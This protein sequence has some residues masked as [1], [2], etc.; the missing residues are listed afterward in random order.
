MRYEGER[1]RCAIQMLIQLYQ[2]L[3]EL[4]L[5]PVW[6]EHGITCELKVPRNGMTFLVRRMFGAEQGRLIETASLLDPTTMHD[7]DP[8]PLARHAAVYET[9]VRD[10]TPRFVGR[11]L[12]SSTAALLNW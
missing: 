10:V 3:R 11:L 9:L 7:I 6:G 1:S 8:Q 12:D 5:Q 4:N 2:A